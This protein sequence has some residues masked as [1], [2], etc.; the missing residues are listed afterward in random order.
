VTSRTTI[1]YATA[2]TA[3]ARQRFG[4]GVVV[5]SVVT[6]TATTIAF[7]AARVCTASAK[8]DYRLTGTAF[9]LTERMSTRFEGGYAG[10]SAVDPDDRPA[11]FRR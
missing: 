6:L 11:T 10:S 9:T 1:R 8:P 5:V 2:S 4:S 3:S 7:G